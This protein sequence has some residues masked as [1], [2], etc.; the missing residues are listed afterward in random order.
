MQAE[1]SVS[2]HPG[3]VDFLRGLELSRD[4]LDKAMQRAEAL[5]A[6]MQQRLENTADGLAAGHREVAEE[7]AEGG[8]VLSPGCFPRY[9]CDLV[10]QPTR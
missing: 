8:A 6:D 10:R 3:T 2:L 9:L 5:A 1:P 4:E 7:L